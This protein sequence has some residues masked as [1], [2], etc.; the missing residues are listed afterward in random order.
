MKTSPH[1]KEHGVLTNEVVIATQ[2]SY[3]LG[4]AL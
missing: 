2:V 1:E 3:C 4:E